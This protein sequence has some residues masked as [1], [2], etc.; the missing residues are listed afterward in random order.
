M[1]SRHRPRDRYFLACY[2][3]TRQAG[4]P[5]ACLWCLM[6]SAAQT[7]ANRLNSQKSTGPRTEAGKSV[8]RMNALQTGIHAESHCIRGEDP[9]ALAQLAAEYHAEFRPVTPLQR[10]LVD[11]LVDNQ[12][13]IRRL[14]ALE[15][16]LWRPQVKFNSAAYE[17]LEL[18]LDRLQRRL[19]SYERSSARAL[20]QLRALQAVETEPLSDEI[21]F[22]PSIPVGLASRPARDLQVPPAPASQP[23]PG[24][25]LSPC[26][27]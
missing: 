13:K 12:W 24:P 18:R 17:D 3:R 15:T 5:R 11:T 4:L 23:P 2:P 16:E 8:S 14:R 9:A 10:D 19:H 7:A 1:A 20:Q 6:A 26:L 21:G 22:V 27:L 25:A